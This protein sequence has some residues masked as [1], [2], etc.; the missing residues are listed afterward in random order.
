MKNFFALLLLITCSAFS[1]LS[2]DLIPFRKGELWGYAAPDKK[3]VIPVK[4]QETMP[5]EYNRGPV[6][7]NNKW[8]YVD[9][10]GKSVIPFKFDVALGF[11]GGYDTIQAM[12]LLE[13]KWVNI[14][15]AGRVKKFK[16][17]PHKEPEQEVSFENYQVITA[18]GLYG[19]KKYVDYY[20]KGKYKSR[21]DTV[22]KPKYPEMKEVTPKLYIA[23][24]QKGKYGIVSPSD[25]I[26]VA[27][28][29]DEIYYY[30]EDK[31]VFLRK[32]NNMG[33]RDLQGHV[34]AE[35]K[36]KTVTRASKNL[37][38]AELH[39][40]KKGYI[41][42]GEEFWDD[43]PAPPKPAGPVPAANTAA[44]KK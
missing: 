19:M 5:F 41:Y 32:G 16:E 15:I 22:M 33:A 31:I 1:V 27:F 38:L 36:Y 2:Q 30:A 7:A 24:N 34:L 23:G 8:G 42:K 13:G 11:F 26:I 25:S 10:T 29:F 20:D 44:K 4:Y 3:I 40:G 37:L 6:M 35:I 14:D 17:P 9:P 28:E 43:N 39:N 21:W 18:N 12:A